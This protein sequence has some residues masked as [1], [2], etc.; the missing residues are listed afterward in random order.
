MP[1]LWSTADFKN[2][3]RNK[4]IETNIPKPWALTIRGNSFGFLITNVDQQK[5]HNLYQNL[6]VT[7]N[8]FQFAGNSFLATFLHVANNQ[9]LFE[10]T[11]PKAVVQA[12]IL[13]HN[14]IVMGNSGTSTRVTGGPAPLLGVIDAIVF[15]NIRGAGTN[16][17]QV[18]NLVNV[19]P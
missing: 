9:F 14:I 7:D 6:F 18:L 12:Y 19:T 13:G 2:I 3:I 5:P 8:I 4:M 1:F 16:N 17:A 10:D 11:P 15:A